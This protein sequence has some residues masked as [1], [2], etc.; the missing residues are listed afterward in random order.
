MSHL[1]KWCPCKC[2]RCKR[3][4][5]RALRASICQVRR[6]TPVKPLSTAC[7]GCQK[8]T[9][10]AEAFA[11]WSTAQEQANKVLGIREEV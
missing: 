1:L 4:F 9:M 8:C 2:P 7:W 10:N 5:T 3:H 6:A 11:T